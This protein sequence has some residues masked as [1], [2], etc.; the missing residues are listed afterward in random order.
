MPDFTPRTAGLTNPE[1]LL[2]FL[3]P[4][5][6]ESLKRAIHGYQ[7]SQFQGVLRHGLRFRAIKVHL[8]I[9]PF[10]EEPFP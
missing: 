1:E 6:I 8:S 5:S 4:D 2:F 7:V 3:N 10:F 9:L